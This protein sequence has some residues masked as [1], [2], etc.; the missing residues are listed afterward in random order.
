MY[1]ESKQMWVRCN[2]CGGKLRKHRILSEHYKS[3][4]DDQGGSETE[5]EYHRIVECMGCEA[6]KYATC[7]RDLVDDE[8]GDQVVYPDASE[9]GSR[10]QLGITKE[11]TIGDDG[12]ELVPGPVWKMY[13]ETIGA[14]RAKIRTLAAGGL[15]AT[16]EAICLD[17]QITG[18]NLQRKIDELVAHG[19]LTKAQA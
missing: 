15:R 11:D 19:F 17:K 7:V 3:L 16:V 8:E 18:A 12:K 1:G 10:H 13:S 5:R 9:Q 6:I 4:Y 2:A 14:L